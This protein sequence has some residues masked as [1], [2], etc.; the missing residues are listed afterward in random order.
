ME[1]LKFF[2]YWIFF[3]SAMWLFFYTATR[4]KTDE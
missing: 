4:K 1:Y 2:A 3:A